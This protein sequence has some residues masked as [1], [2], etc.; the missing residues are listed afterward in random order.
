MAC[1][2]SIRCMDL[3]GR[4]GANRRTQGLIAPP[5]AGAHAVVACLLLQAGGTRAAAMQ[6]VRQLS[7]YPSRSPSPQLDGNQS[8]TP[9]LPAEPPVERGKAPALLAPGRCSGSPSAPLLL[10]AHCRQLG[11]LQAARLPSSV[12][13][14]NTGLQQQQQ[15][16]SC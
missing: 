5:L 8:R 3:T 2:H 15:G 11:S 6:A 13:L 4:G 1:E 12:G 14:G 9:S 16:R 10:R 7:W